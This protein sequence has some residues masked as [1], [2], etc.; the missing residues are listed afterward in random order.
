MVCFVKGL[1]LFKKIL[2]AI[3]H[4]VDYLHNKFEREVAM[5]MFGKAVFCDK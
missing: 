2:N 5:N 4:K 1:S 3:R